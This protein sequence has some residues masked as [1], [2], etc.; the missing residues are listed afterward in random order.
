MKKI[1]L[2]LTVLIAGIAAN[3]Q[4][5]NP[6]T[7]SYSAKKIADKVYEVTIVATI[8]SG[9]HLY[10]QI[11][12]SDAIAIPTTIK[13]N[14]NPLIIKDGKIKE[15][16][17][18]EKYKDKELGISANQ[19]SQTVSFVQKVKLKGK[20]KTNVSGS[21]EFQTCDDKKCL[22]PKTVTFNVPVQ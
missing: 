12:P 8:N 19:Y 22:P 18:L 3:A 17:K 6:V 7:W 14:N 1:L 21:I 10:S 4:I 20:V 2:S 15:V 11:Q 16:G 9:W 13:I 5:Q